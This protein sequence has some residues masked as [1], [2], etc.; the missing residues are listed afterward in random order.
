M[1]YT[2]VNIHFIWSVKNRLPL[3]TH[4]LKPILLSHIRENSKTKE[5]FIDT[6]NCVEDHI[7]LL[8][9][10]GIEQTISKIAMLIKGESSFWVNKQKLIKQKFEWQDEY[11]AL[12]V[13]ESVIDKLRQYIN[14][15]EEHHKKKTF[16]QEYDEFLKLH[17]FNQNNFG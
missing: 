5:I 7:H 3:I 13:S 11:I 4:E 10:L 6:L 1:P 17:E 2:K 8:I 16:T 12:S 15:Q 14:N 9:S